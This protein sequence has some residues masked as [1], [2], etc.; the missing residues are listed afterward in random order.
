MAGI[1]GQLLFRPGWRLRCIDPPIGWVRIDGEPPVVELRLQ[2]TCFLTSRWASPVA[3]RGL[4]LRVNAGG[5]EFLVPWTA[6]ADPDEKPLGDDV[7]YSVDGT[8]PNHAFVD[9]ASDAPDLV[10]YLDTTRRPIPVAVE[11]RFNLAPHFRPIAGLGLEI[12]KPPGRGP[13]W[14]RVQTGRELNQD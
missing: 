8:S 14:R 3:I 2:I 9:F 12:A 13:Q 7:E 6:T 5:R 11:G 10:K 1:F 4:Q